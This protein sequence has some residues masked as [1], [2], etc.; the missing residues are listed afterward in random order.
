MSKVICDSFTVWTFITIAWRLERV[1][2]S[3]QDMTLEMS[4]LEIKS[5]TGAF[6]GYITG[7]TS[8]RFCK[9]DFFPTLL[10]R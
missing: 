3:D 1:S 2:T 5:F 7:T 9:T 6:S 10:Y 4:E 8:G